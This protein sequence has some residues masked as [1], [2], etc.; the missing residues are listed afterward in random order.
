MGYSILHCVST[1]RDFWE[2]STPCLCPPLLVSMGGGSGHAQI[3]PSLPLLPLDLLLAGRVLSPH[4]SSEIGR[5]GL[6]QWNFTM[7]PVNGGGKP[8]YH[9]GKV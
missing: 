3:S 9:K 8:G 4:P 6:L 1:W 5:E 2:S 7:Q